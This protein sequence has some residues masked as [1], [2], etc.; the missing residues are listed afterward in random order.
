MI[1]LI[2]ESISKSEIFKGIEIS[3]IM[4][5]LEN[6]TKHI[7]EFN[8][9]EVIHHQGDI[10]KTLSIV[11]KGKACIQTIKANGDILVLSEFNAGDI[12]AEALL[13]AKENIYPAEVIALSNLSIMEFTREEIMIMMT[14]NTKVSE[15]IVSLLS[16]K[17]VMLKKKINL[18]EA[19]SVREKI[20]RLILQKSK[21]QQSNI[22]KIKSKKILAEEIGIPRPSFSRE[23]IKMKE[24]GIIDYTLKEITILDIDSIKREII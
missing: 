22:I 14:K 1:N 21:E 15:N 11:V 12:F 16:D 9:G 23:L 7:K 4:E 18:I 13:F 3:I 24:D 20:C 8:K 17:I 6:I 2:L 10:C 19:G 5:L